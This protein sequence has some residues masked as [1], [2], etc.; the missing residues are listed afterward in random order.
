MSRK[1][2][3]SFHDTGIPSNV[4]R[5]YKSKSVQQ[6]VNNLCDKLDI[7]APTVKLFN[8]TGHTYTSYY[9]CTKV[10]N[11]SK[12]AVKNLPTYAWV[13]MVAHEIGHHY[14]LQNNFH[15]NS[16]K[17]EVH[18][19]DKIAAKLTSPQSV[20]RALHYFQVNYDPQH[21]PSDLK[22]DQE[23]INA[24]KK[25]QDSQTSV[26]NALSSAIHAT[27]D[28]KKPAVSSTAPSSAVKQNSAERSKLTKNVLQTIKGSL[29]Q[30]KAESA[31]NDK[32]MKAIQQTKK[33]QQAKN[34]VLDTIKQSLQ[35]TSAT[36][37]A[38]SGGINIKVHS[39][40]QKNVQH[41]TKKNLNINRNNN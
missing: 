16:K 19:A 13:G 6:I 41:K 21:K 28:H 17:E 4:L 9:E 7:K 29:E 23:R 10:I 37:K 32:K 34:A 11:V 18:F 5:G 30:Q 2:V 25:V 40:P 33:K 36:P 15:F 39:K 27:V 20:I 12:A 38:Q 3:N 14:A 22:S 35:Q 26:R 31:S 8:D 24:L 1:D